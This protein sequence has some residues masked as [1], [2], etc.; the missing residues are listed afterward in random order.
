VADALSFLVSLTTTKMG[1]KGGGGGGGKKSIATKWFA[2]PI[3]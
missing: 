3:T 2:R 1:K